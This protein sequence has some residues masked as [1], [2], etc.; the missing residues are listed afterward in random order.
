ME[1]DD[2]SSDSITVEDDDSDEAVDLVSIL[3]IK[4][5]EQPQPADNTWGAIMVG[6]GVLLALVAVGALFFLTTMGFRT[7]SSPG[8]KTGGLRSGGDSDDGAGHDAGSS[9]RSANVTETTA[10]RHINI[11]DVTRHH[12]GTGQLGNGSSATMGNANENSTGSAGGTEMSANA[13][14]STGSPR[15]SS[16]II[17]STGGFWTG[18][19]AT[20][21]RRISSMPPAS[22]LKPLAYSVGKPMTKTPLVCVFG[23][24]I[25]WRMHF[26]D[27]G[28]C[29]LLFYDSLYGHTD[30]RFQTTGNNFTA[31]LRRWLASVKAY[32]I[33]EG[34]LGVASTGVDQARNDIS[35]AKGKA[36]FK[37]LLGSGVYHYGVLDFAATNK[38]KETDI[39]AT[40]GLLKDLRELLISYDTKNNSFDHH[41]AVGITYFKEVNQQIYGSIEKAISKEAIRLVI[42]RTHLGSRDEVDREHCRITGSTVWGEPVARM[43]PSIEKALDYVRQ[44]GSSFSESTRILLSVSLAGRWY[45]SLAGGENKSAYAVGAKCKPFEFATGMHELDS[46][47]TACTEQ[48]YAAHVTRDEHREVMSTYEESTGLAFVFESERTL[49]AKASATTSLTLLALWFARR[50]IS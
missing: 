5:P 31:D 40:F 41:L 50:E 3:K 29:D 7:S 21:T 16:G 36:T 4:T 11:V 47:V 8:V 30:N 24:R 10:A 1:E 15:S 48:H 6:A 34:G 18:G 22:K 23:N 28:L 25:D 20:T 19:N 13:T 39:T 17:S 46:R 44:R 42:L 49:Y 33:T 43:H 35:S 26:P 38:T 2:D 9:E 12:K 27:D 14:S 37:S 45:A 32:N